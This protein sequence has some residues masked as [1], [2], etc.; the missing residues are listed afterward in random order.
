MDG[1]SG[2]IYALSVYCGLTEIASDSGKATFQT[3]HDN[4]A[5]KAACSIS[6]VKR[7]LIVLKKLGLIAV[8]TPPALMGPC[9][10]SLLVSPELTSVQNA[11]HTEG[12]TL[13]EGNKKEEEPSNNLARKLEE[14]G[15][16][17]IWKS[18]AEMI[19]ALYPRKIGSRPMAIKA[20][21]RALQIVGVGSLRKAV[22]KFSQTPDAI[23]DGG[24]YCPAPLKWF[25]E[26]KWKDFLPLPTIPAPVIVA[27]SQALLDVRVMFSKRI[28]TVTETETANVF[29]DRLT[30][31][32]ENLMSKNEKD[33]A[34]SMKLARSEKTAKPLNQ[35]GEER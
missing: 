25:S 7:A 34:T 6:G 32:D 17:H 35:T 2:C 14:I 33:W 10:Y 30:Q 28:L 23:R 4:I 18:D 16:D 1:Q 21:W 24:K 15:K 22:I 5:S 13:E 29:L 31:D 26:E 11:N 20:I 27:P 3:S 9:T 19:F 8:T 12:A